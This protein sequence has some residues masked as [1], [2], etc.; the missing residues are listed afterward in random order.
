MFNIEVTKPYKKI[1][2]FMEAVEYQCDNKYIVRL[3][4]I[5]NETSIKFIP[6]TAEFS[7]VAE[8]NEVNDKHVCEFLFS[9]TNCIPTAVPSEIDN[10]CDN[11]NYINSLCNHFKNNLRLFKK[12]IIPKG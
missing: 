1:N 3:T 9:D 12:G 7:P 6:I 4:S 8:M 2:D 11:I 10:I 5:D